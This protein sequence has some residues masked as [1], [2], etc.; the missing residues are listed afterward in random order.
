[1]TSNIGRNTQPAVRS[2]RAK[3]RGLRRTAVWKA[4]AAV[5]LLGAL[6]AWQS[7]AVQA[8]PPHDTERP[9]CVAV[10][11]EPTAS[12][13]EAVTGGD[14]KRVIHWTVQNDPGTFVNNYKKTHAKKVSY[15]TTS[16]VVPATGAHPR[17][18]FQASY[19]GDVIVSDLGDFT[20]AAVF[21]IFR[22]HWVGRNP[23]PAPPDRPEVWVVTPSQDG[24]RALSATNDGE[25][26][27]WDT[28]PPNGT[29]IAAVAPSGH[30]VGGLAFVPPS[31]PGTQETQFLAGQGDG[32]MI[33]YNI[34]QTGAVTKLNPIR[35]FPHGN[36][37]PVNSVAVT[38]GPSPRQ[39][40]LSAARRPSASGRARDGDRGRRGRGP[41]AN[42][43][44]YRADPVHPSRPTT[45]WFGASRSRRTRQKSHRRARTGRCDCSA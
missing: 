26:L 21:T 10:A 41:S 5:A 29:I 23:I 8:F 33:L 14:S 42:E 31:A 3:L 30:P 6:A 36:A 20:N 35:P 11:S 34:V 39:G 16:I 12:P 44:P 19:D 43:G 4:A 45:T 7:V 28:A 27:L 9:C 40:Q 32:N 1:M 38:R 22:G 2:A 17:K 25:I 37:F 15:V 13:P 24:S 18:L